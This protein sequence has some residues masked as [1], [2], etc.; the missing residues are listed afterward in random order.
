MHSDEALHWAAALALCSL[1]LTLLIFSIAALPYVLRSYLDFVVYTKDSLQ[2]VLNTIKA[3]SMLSWTMLQMGWWCL[4]LLMILYCG[5]T[6][7]SII[8]HVDWARTQS[9]LIYD[10]ISTQPA[11]IWLKLTEHHKSFPEFK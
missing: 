1:S 10:M 4:V 6:L 8:T 2:S 3:A 9:S 7:W 11:Q 5:Q